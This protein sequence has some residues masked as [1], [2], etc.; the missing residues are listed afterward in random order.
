M[1]EEP[2]VS[3]L[4]APT[5]YFSILSLLVVGFYISGCGW[6]VSVNR[7]GSSVP[8]LSG[9]T[10]CLVFHGRDREVGDIDV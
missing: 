6:S 3:A 4:S 7:C 10:R 9:R 1:R 8:G 2:A 5:L